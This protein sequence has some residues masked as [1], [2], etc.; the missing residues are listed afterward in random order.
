[1][2]QAQQIFVG[3]GTDGPN[4]KCNGVSTNTYAA[5]AAVTQAVKDFCSDQGN[6][7]GN[8]DT[9]TSKSFNN[10]I[11]L[12]IYWPTKSGGDFSNWDISTDECQKDFGPTVSGCDGNDAVHNPADLKHGGVYRSDAGLK[13]TYQP[14]KGDPFEKSCNGWDS[15]QKAFM[16]PDILKQNVL[17]VCAHAA[18][19][20]TGGKEGQYSNSYNSNT[21]DAAFLK[22]AWAAGTSLSADN[23]VNDMSEL[24]SGC[25]GDPILNQFDFKW[26]GEKGSPSLFYQVSPLTSRMPITSGGNSGDAGNGRSRGTTGKDGKAIDKAVLQMCLAGYGDQGCDGLDCAGMLSAVVWVWRHADL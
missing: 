22:V 8:Q 11:K 16:K 18:Q 25:D 21:D 19:F 24:N 4:P 20:A 1:L 2:N 7:H 13:Y 3:G 15:G 17:D 10:K 26:G 23:C 14:L 9:T 6:L 5:E 12:T